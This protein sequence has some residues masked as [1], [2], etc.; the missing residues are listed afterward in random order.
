MA[1]VTAIVVR[2]EQKELSELLRTEKRS[3]IKERIQVLYLLKQ[4]IA[5]SISEIAKVIG[6]HRGT[7]QKWLGIYREQGL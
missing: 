4:Q 6:K 3:S 1:G 2:E 7:V 5:P